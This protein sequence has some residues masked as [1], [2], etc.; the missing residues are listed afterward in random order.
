MHIVVA[1]ATGFLGTALVARL[2]GEGHEV[3]V[4]SRDAARAAQALGVSAVGW[5]QEAVWREAVGL[6]DAVINLA[7]ESVAARRWN[8][9]FK[10]LLELSRVEP[11]KLLAS[12]HPKVLLNASAVG[13]YGDQGDRELTEGSVASYDFFGD[14]C[15]AWESA[16]H[17][18]QVQGGRVVLLRIGQVLGKG[19]GMLESVLH[20]PMVP[21]SPWKLGLGGPLG[22]GKQWVPWVHVDDVVGLFCHALNNT[23]IAGP[24]NVVS[25]NPVTAQVFAQELGKVLHKPSKVAVPPFALRAL[26]GEFA[27][28]VLASQKVLPVRAQETGYVFQYPELPGA[29]EALLR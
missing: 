27:E 29:L 11:T 5:D 14:L 16:T 4:L 28:F 22:S 10:Q 26:L 6:A 23:T 17:E 24:M 3:I 15:L 13:F 1:G 25:P 7:G 21:F 19:A 8:A 9:G 2:K 18:A 20:P 12:A